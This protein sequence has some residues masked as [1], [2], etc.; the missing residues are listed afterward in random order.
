MIWKTQ[1]GCRNELI[2]VE[3][4][5]IDLIVPERTKDQLIQWY[6]NAF[7]LLAILC[8]IDNNAVQPIYFDSRSE[9]AVLCKNVR[10]ATEA[11][12]PVSMLESWE[13]VVGVT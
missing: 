9:G 1:P 4:S 2:I 7:V 3:R 5:G 12:M 13:Y 10:H 6:V 11:K 8:V